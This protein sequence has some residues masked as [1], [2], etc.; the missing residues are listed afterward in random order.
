MVGVI[1]RAF[2]DAPEGQI[3]YRYIFMTA[4]EK[5]APVVFLHQSA[6][7]GW[8]YQLMMKEYVE[9]GHDCYAP[10]MPG[11]AWPD[12][13]FPARKLKQFTDSL[14]SF[15][16][17]YNPPNDPS[18]TR[19]YVDIWMA[20]FR[21]LKLSKMHLVGH[22]SGSAHAMEMAAVYSDEIFT[23]ALSGPALMS[24]E[25]QAASYKVIGGEFSKVGAQQSCLP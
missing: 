14:F 1:K 21:H 11:S 20:L 12:F 6:S 4:I 8:S 7:C 2:W 13:F 3:H 10:D 9:R 16:C 19:Y 23:A 24:E 15:G 22:H 17:S 25:E 5:K 18:S